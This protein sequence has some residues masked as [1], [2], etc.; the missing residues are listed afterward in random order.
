MAAFQRGIGLAEAQQHMEAAEAVPTDGAELASPHLESDHTEPVPTGFVST[1][2]VYTGE[3]RTGGAYLSG[4]HGEPSRT[5]PSPVEPSPTEFPHLN[6]ADTNGVHTGGLYVNA[7]HAEPSA[8]EPSPVEP[9]PLE[10]PHLSATHMGSGYMDTALHRYTAQPTTPDTTLAPRLDA[11]PISEAHAHVPGH[12]H[13]L[14][15][16]HDGSASAG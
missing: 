1:G 8:P 13:D 9:S 15:A 6:G 5:D 3:V 16:R 7:L 10:Q 4:L 14:T 2:E 12:D 11:A